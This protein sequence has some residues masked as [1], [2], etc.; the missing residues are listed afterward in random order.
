MKEDTAWKAG[1]YA[2][3]VPG[4]YAAAAVASAP[5]VATV[6]VTA[7]AIGALF[8]VALVPIAI[9]GLAMWLNEKINGK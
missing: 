5:V 8:T 1:V 4:A 6:G 3:V 9:G 7:A 2:G